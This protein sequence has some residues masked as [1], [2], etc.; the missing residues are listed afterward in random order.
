MCVSACI[1]VYARVCACESVCECVCAL[2][3]VDGICLCMHASACIC[4]CAYVRVCSV[5]VCMVCVACLYVRVCVCVWCVCGDRV[6]LCVYANEFACIR[7]AVH[8]ITCG[9]MRACIR[10]YISICMF[11][12][13]CV[14]VCRHVRMSMH[15]LDITGTGPNVHEHGCINACIGWFN[16]C[17]HRC[18]HARMNSYACIQAHTLTKQTDADIQE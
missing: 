2:L 11:V 8:N 16:V 6:C 15:I 5:C 14:S 1:C 10:V 7:V 4:E 18:M 3:C 9:F 13:M 12:Y 17:I